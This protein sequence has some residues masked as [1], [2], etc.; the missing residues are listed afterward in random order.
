MALRSTNLCREMKNEYRGADRILF[1]YDQK[2]LLINSLKNA[3]NIIVIALPYI[4]LNELNN[5][6]LGYIE[7]A[8][9]RGINIFIGY[10]IDTTKDK[11]N[12]S[13]QKLLK[14]QRKRYGE[15]LHLIRLKHLYEKILIK[16]NEYIVITTFNWVPFKEELKKGLSVKTAVDKGFHNALSS[17]LDSN[18]TTI[19]AGLV[20]YYMGTG[21][22]K[23]FAV[24]LMIGIVV[25]MFTALVV[26]KTLMKLGV[27][28]GLLKTPAH[29]RVKR[30]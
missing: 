13:V 26:T 25:S 30:G 6:I 17:I 16:D 1:T 5:E 14:I 3:Q 15:N 10:G 22:V 18:I 20:L 19:I 9:Q 2:P 27:N 8:L 21:T 11:S 4:K 12:L 23:G 28:M 24:T 29:F 7:K